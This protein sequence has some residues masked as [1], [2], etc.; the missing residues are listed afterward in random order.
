MIDDPHITCQYKTKKFPLILK[1]IDDKV[2]I[3]KASKEYEKFLFYEIVAINNISIQEITKE[4]EKT[5]SYSAIGHLKSQLEFDLM[6]GFSILSLPLFIDKEDDTIIY[7]LQKNGEYQ[8]IIFNWHDNFNYDF[9]ENRLYWFDY[10]SINN[11]L[12]IKYKSCYSDPKKTMEQFVEELK[13][14]VQKNPIN[15]VI[16]DI[17]GNGGGKSGIIKPLIVFLDASKFNLVTLVDDVVYSSGRWALVDLKRIGSKLIG[18]ETG[19]ATNCFGYI[20]EF[21]LPYTKMLIKCSLRY[22]Y[23]KDQYM[24]TVTKEEFE[25]FYKNP[26]NK[27]YF[28]YSNIEPDIY[29]K[30]KFEDYKNHYDRELNEAKQYFNEKKCKTALKYNV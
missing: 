25:S 26:Q 11:I 22:L 17:R 13:D 28:T 15:N 3:M 5:I 14:F 1:I 20:T 7:K 6:R 19:T 30:N 8:E 12:I 18:T 23:Y 24:E 21:I 27:Q 29:V 9:C 10:D 16:V 2:I 4:L